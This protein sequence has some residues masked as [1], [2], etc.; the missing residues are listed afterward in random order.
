MRSPISHSNP[1]ECNT[2]VTGSFI[3]SNS[4]IGLEIWDT[5][6][7]ERHS[8]VVGAYFK[9]TSGVMLVYD[10]TSMES[11]LNIKSWINL[12]YDHMDIPNRLNS[13]AE[14][15]FILVG[16]KTDLVL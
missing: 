13:K 6:G 10:I 5:L 2:P 12:L 7:Q 3:G 1:F 9:N 4:S 11:F 16:N 15:A 8:S 14:E